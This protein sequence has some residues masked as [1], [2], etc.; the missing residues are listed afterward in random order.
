M[1]FSR[2][3][4]DCLLEGKLKDERHYVS[5]SKQSEDCLLASKLKD[6]RP[7]LRKEHL[8]VYLTFY[9]S[10]HFELPQILQ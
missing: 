4:D 5:L 6:R 7:I 1:G 10:G 9:N 8:G 2:Q 3:S